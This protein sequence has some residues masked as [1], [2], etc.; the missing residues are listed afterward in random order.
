MVA[1][2]ALFGY[3]NRWNDTMATTLEPLAAEVA[4]RARSGRWGGRRENTAD[5]VRMRPRVDANS[6]LAQPPDVQCPPKPP[7]L[8]IHAGCTTMVVSQLRHLGQ[9]T[10]NANWRT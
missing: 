2:I 9:T 7:K 10:V 5:R 8:L 6:Q 3:L 4:E 1:A